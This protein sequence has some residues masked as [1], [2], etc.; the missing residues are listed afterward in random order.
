[1]VKLVATNLL[2]IE[3]LIWHLNVIEKI[4]EMMVFF[5]SGLQAKS[6]FGLNR[7]T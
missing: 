5:A 2:F 6:R 7:Q 3:T 4:C 1:M